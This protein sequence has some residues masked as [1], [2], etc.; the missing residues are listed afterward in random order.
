V[1][2]SFVNAHVTPTQRRCNEKQT[3]DKRLNA[4]TRSELLSRIVAA[5][6]R[7][8]WLIPLISFASG[9]IGFVLIKRGESLAGAIAWIAFVGWLW[10]LI[11]P[12]VRRYLEQ[13]RAGV[14][15]F[16]ANFFSQSLQQ[17]M[18]FFSLPLM[19][20][21][22]QR[23]AGQI[24]FTALAAIAAL[25]T[26]LD[27]IYERYI[28]S[29]A[30]SRLLFHAYCSLIA[31]VVVLPMVVHIP[32]ERA[33]PLSLVTVGAWLVLTLPMSLR[34]LKNPRHKAIWIATSLLGPLLLWGLRSH[35]PA[36]GM[37]VTRALVAQSISNLTPGVAVQTLTSVELSQGVV[38]FVAIRAPRGVAQSVIFEWRHGDEAERIVAEIHGGNEIGWRTYSRKQLFPKD[39]RGVWIVDVLTPQQQLIKRLRF[40]V[41]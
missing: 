18:L 17:E 35:I 32:L 16:V 38:A 14:G 25:L 36:A 15:K 8:P 37:A 9:W 23:D 7:V 29:R 27:P 26:T 3:A 5:V 19:V 39:S 2:A 6:H 21:A 41:R 40:E 30:A 13:R 22:T 12:S 10:L 1:P 34:S 20:G 28:A 4:I 31:A 24:S 11:E 33:L